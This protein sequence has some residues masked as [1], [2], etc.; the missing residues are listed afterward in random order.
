MADQRHFDG[1]EKTV[2]DL[3]R[4]QSS[5]AA[6]LRNRL[7]THTHADSGGGG[8]TD[9]GALTGLADD[10]HPQYH[11][12]ARGDARYY[13]KGQ[14]D[15]LLDAKED[16]GVA[17]AAVSAHVADANPHSQYARGVVAFYER[18]SNSAA[19]TTVTGV[20]VSYT[21]FSMQAG[22]LY[23]IGAYLGVWSDAYGRADVKIR[24]TTNNTIPTTSSP[25]LTQGSVELATTSVVDSIILTGLYRPSVNMS[26]V[27]GLF[28]GRSSGTGNVFSYGDAAWPASLYIEDVGPDI[29]PV[30]AN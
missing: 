9:H 18:T 4:R 28:V 13:T 23:R 29:A 3:V 11:N 1:I 17:A 26:F 24:Y 5:D 21:W 6:Q 20:R 25:Q 27:A 15:T 7:A 8:V 2:A 22:R 14:A 10:D 16:D 12:D 19:A 30:G